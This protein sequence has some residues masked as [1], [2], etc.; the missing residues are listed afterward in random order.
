VPYALE[1]GF[2]YVHEAH[3][4]DISVG[5]AIVVTVD[6]GNADAQSEFADCVLKRSNRGNGRALPAVKI[7]MGKVS[8]RGLG[9]ADGW[10]SAVR[11]SSFDLEQLENTATLIF[12]GSSEER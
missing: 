10:D 7:W 9:G 12:R 5:A 4:A 11:C 3:L 1:D 2:T 8:R 6:G